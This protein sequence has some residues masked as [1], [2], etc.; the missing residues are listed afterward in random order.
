VDQSTFAT[1]LMQ[2]GNSTQPSLWERGLRLPPLHV[3]IEVS[4]VLGVSLDFLTGESAEWE[5]DA[6]VAARGAVFRRI[7]RMFARNAEAVS[8]ALLD[9]CSSPGAD[10]LRI[11]KFATRAASLCD[12]VD[13]FEKL[14]RPLFDDARGG[15]T[16]KRTAGEMRDALMSVEKF[17][18]RAAQARFHALERARHQT[19]ARTEAQ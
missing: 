19:L 8:E 3:L 7:Q 16:L 18:Q 4:R 1:E 9:C 13:N 11:S 6:R 15:A 12:A 10:E 14:N 2:F 5:R 17:L